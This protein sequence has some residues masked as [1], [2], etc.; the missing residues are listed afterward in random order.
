MIDNIGVGVSRETIDRLEAFSTLTVKWTMKINLISKPSVPDIWNRHIIDSAQIF[1]YAREAVHWVDIGSGGGF[2]AIVLAI[3]AKEIAPLTKFTLIES[4]AR[5]CTFLR[6]AIREFDLNAYVM[7]QR[8]EDV[9]AQYADVV[10]ARALGG[11]PDLLPHIKR[12]ISPTGSALLMK[13]RKYASELES[14]SDDWDFDLVEYPSITD[15]ESRIL[16]LKRI[17]RVG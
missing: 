1:P 11:L 2:P 9:E 14:V 4:D 8:I 3:M 15:P 17:T 5:K 16:L 6:T 13:G 12:H 7:T 10:S